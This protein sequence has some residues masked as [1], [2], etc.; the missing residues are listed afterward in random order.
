MY[1]SC[2]ATAAGIDAAFVVSGIHAKEC[3]YEGPKNGNSI[4]TWDDSRLQS[5]LK[6]HAITPRYTVGGMLW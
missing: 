5:M 4:G 3:A 1:M 2:R 6:Q